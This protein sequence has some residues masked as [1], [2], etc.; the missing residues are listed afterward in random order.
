M[1]HTLLDGLAS[2]G[3]LQCVH[4][5]DNLCKAVFVVV[6]NLSTK[7]GPWLRVPV[8]KQTLDRYEREAGLSKAPL[9]LA[10]WGP[11]VA[12]TVDSDA[13]KQA[14]YAKVYQAT[15]GDL[16]R[17]GIGGIKAWFCGSRSPLE[18]K[19]SKTKYTWAIFSDTKPVGTVFS[20]D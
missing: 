6:F 14:T 15:A 16:D 13:A 5:L 7:V 11:S 19:K 20:F 1:T 2:K 4:L 12:L 8:M 18:N 3:E 10:E 17:R 9:L